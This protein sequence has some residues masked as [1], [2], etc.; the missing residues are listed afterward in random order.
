[1]TQVAQ[2]MGHQNVGSA[3]PVVGEPFPVAQRGL[4]VGQPGAQLGLDLRPA[5]FGPG[6]ARMEDVDAGQLADERLDA[7]HGGEQPGHDHGPAA[8]VGGHQGVGVLGDPQDDGAAFKHLDLAVAIGRHLAERLSGAI[9]RSQP[10]LVC[11]Q[12]VVIAEPGLLQRPAHADVADRALGERRHPLEGGDLN[13]GG[14]L[15]RFRAP[16]APRR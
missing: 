4:E 5:L 16:Y 1:M 12:V 14:L 10:V 11:D 8:C 13:H 2:H 15:L 3:E 7:V 6:L 9:L